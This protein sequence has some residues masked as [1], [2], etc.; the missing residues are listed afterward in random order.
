MSAFGIRRISVRL[1]AWH[2][3]SVAVLLAVLSVLLYIQLRDRLNQDVD[4]QL[5]ESASATMSLVEFENDQL[6]FEGTEPG[7]SLADYPQGSEAWQSPVRLVDTQGH[8]VSAAP[9][10]R[11]VAFDA[12]AALALP[13]E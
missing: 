4:L 2:V 10:F 11:E 1:I 7:R 13:N 5:R 3:L 9:V 12:K 6:I 8:E